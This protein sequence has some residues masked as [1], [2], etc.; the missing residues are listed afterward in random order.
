M[1]CST[2]SNHLISIFRKLLHDAWL[3]FRAPSC[4]VL[5]FLVA[6]GKVTF[7]LSE[8]LFYWSKT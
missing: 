7:D 1:D 2:L 4:V 5:E 3:Y 8:V 6:T